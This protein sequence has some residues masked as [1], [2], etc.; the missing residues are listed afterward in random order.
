LK[1]EPKPRDPVYLLT[2]HG[3]GYKFLT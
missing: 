2:V 3:A 1:L